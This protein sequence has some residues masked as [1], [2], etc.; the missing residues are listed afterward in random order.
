MALTHSLIIKEQKE[1]AG[2]GYKTFLSF[3]LR[4]N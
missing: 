4:Q 1:I 3:T 2:T